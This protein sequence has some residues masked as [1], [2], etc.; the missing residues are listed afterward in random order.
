ME[1]YKIIKEYGIS[2][3]VNIDSF[4]GKMGD[5]DVTC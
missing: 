3:K 1:L 2:E 5:K 4:N